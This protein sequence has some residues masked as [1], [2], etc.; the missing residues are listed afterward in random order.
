[1]LQAPQPLPLETILTALVNELAAVP[2]PFLLIL[3]DYHTLDSPQVDEALTFLLDYQ[4]PQLHL[5][6][7]SREDPNLPLARL[8]ARGQLTELRAADLRFT[9][10]NGRLPQHPHAARPDPAGNRRPGR[11]H[12]RMGRRAANG[13]PRPAGHAGARRRSPRLPGIVRR[14]PPLYVLDYLL[15]EVLQQQPAEVRDFLLRTAVLDQLNGP[16][17]DAVLGEAG[18]G[19]GRRILDTLEKSNLFLVPLD[20]QRLWYRYHH[21]FAEVLQAH[22]HDEPGIDIAALHRRAGRWYAEQDQLAPAIHHTLAAADF[23]AAAALLEAVWPEMNQSFQAAG[24]LQWAR[25][26]PDAAVIARP[27][28]GAQYA[29]ALIDNGDMDG[30]IGRVREVEQ[31]N[32]VA[33]L[34]DPIPAMLALARAQIALVHGEFDTAVDYARHGQSLAGDDFAAA[35]ASQR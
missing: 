29:W 28:L 17:C 11:A 35:R 27:L 14:Q 18:A 30:A 12:R 9:G 22:L 8:R 25:Q 34:E 31:Q 16:L 4:P 33:T 6:L 24:W 3:D 5:V 26:L 1:M 10:G 19:N 23:P 15:E 2:D 32:N 21:L 13:R 7:G 20:A